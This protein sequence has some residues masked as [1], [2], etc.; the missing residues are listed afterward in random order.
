MKIFL[1]EMASPLPPKCIKCTDF[2]SVMKPPLSLPCGHA[3]CKICTCKLELE[4]NRKC[5]K[6]EETWI[7]DLVEPS[8]ANIFKMLSTHK[9]S[10][11]TPT[12]EEE[13]QEDCN[14]DSEERELSKKTE[15][16]QVLCADH[17]EEVQFYCASCDEL[18]CMECVTSKHKSHDFCTLKNGGQ[19]V[20][21]AI[22]KALDEARAKSTVETKIVDEHIAKTGQDKDL[23]QNF[24]IDVTH[25]KNTKKNIQKKLNTQREALISRF[26][27]F[28]AV[29][30][31]LETVEQEISPHLIEE[32]QG[33]LK[34]PPEELVGA[35]GEENLILVMARAYMVSYFISDK[36]LVHNRGKSIIIFSARRSLI[37]LCSRNTTLRE[38][39]SHFDPKKKKN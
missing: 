21:V 36:S 24:E 30:N 37:K 31:K 33:N 12:T 17:E 9:E 19:K 4:N 26:T 34:Y 3:L 25:E 10:A 8:F 5:P 14:L 38:K 32:L 2:Y 22:T 6:C 15:Q 28:D 11:R 18:L 16:Q 7:E 29:T 23:L 20:K 27:R 39:W 35:S 1:S 13:H